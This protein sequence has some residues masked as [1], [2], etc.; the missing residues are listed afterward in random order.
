MGPDVDLDAVA[1]LTQGFC[2]ADLANVVNEAALLTARRGGDVISMTMVEEGIDRATLGLGSRATI[3]S[4]EERR[5][6]AYHEAGHALVAL[7]VPGASPPHK[8]TIVPRGGTL[9]HCSMLDTHDRVM[10]SKTMLMGRMA[11]FLGGMIAE[12]LVIGESGTGPSSDLDRVGEIAR[13]MVRNYGMGGALG[14]LTYPDRRGFS[15]DSAR[16]IDAE[17]RRLVEDARAMATDVLRTHRPALD[18]VARALLD[19][20]TLTADELEKTAALGKSP[21]RSR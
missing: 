7:T 6:V 12:E 5:V 10:L 9:G 13:Q 15:E 2:G 14:P 21:G 17:V 18:R 3:M 4:E 16:M 8:L 1:G 11:M 20:E 19:H